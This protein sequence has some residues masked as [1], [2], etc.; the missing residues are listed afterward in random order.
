MLQLSKRSCNQYSTRIV[1]YQ[2]FAA[3]N[4][5]KLAKAIE[6]GIPDALRGMMWQLMYVAS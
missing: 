3:S 5:Q 4:P 1:D 2:G 6:K